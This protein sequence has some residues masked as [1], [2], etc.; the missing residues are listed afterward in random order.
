MPYEYAQPPLLEISKGTFL[1]TGYAEGQYNQGSVYQ[2]TVSPGSPAPEVRITPSMPSFYPGNE[3]ALY[4]SS[5]GTTACT[6]S[7]AWSGSQ[8]TTSWTY[9]SPSTPGTYTYTLTCNTASGG[10]VTAST[11]V[12][13]LTPP[14]PYIY[15]PLGNNISVT[16]LSSTEML[17]TVVHGKALALQWST[18]YATSCTGGDAWSGSVPTAGTKYVNISQLGETTYTLTCTGLGGTSSLSLIVQVIAQMPAITSFTI[19]PSTINLGQ[20]ALMQ[21]TTTAARKCFVDNHGMLTNVKVNG[22]TVLKPTATGIYTYSLTCSNGTLG[23]TES[24]TLTV[25]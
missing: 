15:F 8:P 18:A 24:V 1:D 19:T 25:N 7:G 17:G 4:W 14:A 21:W 12:T 3:A 13:V 16:Q 11:S 9:V 22:Q 20:S 10:T 6:A 23:D 5:I 2:L